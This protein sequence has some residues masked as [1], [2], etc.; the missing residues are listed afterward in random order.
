M[1]HVIET[2]TPPPDDLKAEACTSIHKLAAD[3]GEVLVANC[4]EGEELKQAMIR[5][6]ECA[7][8]ACIAIQRGEGG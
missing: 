7:F 1:P 3:F 6:D 2:Q 5:L 8:W 4:P